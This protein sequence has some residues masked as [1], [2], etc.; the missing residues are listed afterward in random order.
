MP[1]GGGRGAMGARGRGGCGGGA[2]GGG[3]GLWGGGGC[4]G[5]MG[6]PPRTGLGPIFSFSS[7]GSS[8]FTL[9]I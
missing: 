1:G 3:G 9:W 2:V 5:G 7:S 4:F 6:P 8:P